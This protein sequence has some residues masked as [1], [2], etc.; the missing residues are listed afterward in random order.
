MNRGYLTDLV[1]SS[2]IFFN[3][4]AAFSKEL[5]LVLSCTEET[6]H[7]ATNGGTQ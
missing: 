1:S 2:E 4:L 7:A 6:L 3:N 5:I